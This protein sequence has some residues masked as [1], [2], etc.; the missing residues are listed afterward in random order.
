VQMLEVVCLAHEN[1][2]FHAIADS[3][4]GGQSVLNHL[5]INCDLTSRLVMDARLYDPPPRRRPG[6]NGR[7][8]IR[9]ARL[10]SPEQMLHHRLPRR[11]LT[12][13][14]KT[15]PARLADTV[16]RVYKTPDRPLRVV[17]VEPLTGQRGRQA[18]YSTAHDADAEQVLQWYAMRWAIEVTFHDA[19]QHLG[20]EQPQGW[21]PK[22]TQRTAPIAM[23]LYTLVIL[24]FDQHG[25]RIY[26]PIHRPWY[27][28]K[29]HPSFAD[30]LATLKQTSVRREV[31]ATHLAGR[32]SRKTQQ[33]ACHLATL[34]A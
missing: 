13:Y 12:L 34:A 10:D 27:R 19:K 2:Q 28:G 16:A 26:K 25:R 31:L 18:F 1:K 29:S 24:W 23:L 5:P 11:E 7:P 20:F 30:M 17:A 8:R 6:T 33:L 15:T 32:G 21:T 4:Y 22:A 3:A 14:G 9:G